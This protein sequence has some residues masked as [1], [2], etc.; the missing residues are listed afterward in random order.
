MSKFFLFYLF[1]CCLYHIRNRERS[2]FI[3]INQ[4][5]DIANMRDLNFVLCKS[6]KWAISNTRITL[7]INKKNCQQNTRKNKTEVREEL[8]W[9]GKKWHKFI[10]VLNSN[11]RVE[12]R[13]FNRFFFHWICDRLEMFYSFLYDVLWLPF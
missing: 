9:A 6:R 13:L 2:S 5:L 12:G 8:L 3:C 11:L 4:N 10:N 7:Q 1:C